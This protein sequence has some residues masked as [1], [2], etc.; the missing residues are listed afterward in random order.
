MVLARGGTPETADGR[1]ASWFA[2][3][4]TGSPRPEAWGGR[5]DRAAT[6]MMAKPLFLRTPTS[7]SPWNDQS[8]ETTVWHDGPARP[9]LAIEALLPRE[10][11]V[12]SSHRI[13]TTARQE[14]SRVGTTD[15]AHTSR[16]PTGERME[17]DD[18]RGHNRCGHLQLRPAGRDGYGP[19]GA[20]WRRTC[21]ERRVRHP[22]AERAKR[23][24]A[25]GDAPLERT[26]VA[27]RCPTVVGRL[28]PRMNRMTSNKME[29]LS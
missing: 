10:S 6:I 24:E 26:E 2:T 3:L 29:T 8:G 14:P 25:H 16:V 22:C 9:T 5:A 13:R 18:H 17:G 27:S 20:R 19:C 1:S 12:P 28:D 4:R 11:N 15:A 21:Q 7:V 23:N